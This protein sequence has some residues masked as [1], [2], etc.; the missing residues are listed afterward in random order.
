MVYR[1]YTESEGRQFQSAAKHAA[2]KALV[3]MPMDA[4][5]GSLLIGV[6][7][8]SVMAIGGFSQHG[9]GHGAHGGHG[10]GGGAHGHGGA[11]HGSGGHGHV[12]VGNG[13]PS[14]FMMVLMSPR[15]F[16]AWLIGVGLSGM[17]L[18]S[19]LG[20]ALLAV[21]AI[22]GGVLFERLLVAPLWKLA[23]RF[24]SD[25][26]LTLESALDSEATAVSAFDQEGHGLIALEID[27]QV[28]QL[29]GTLVAKDRE[30]GIKV[31]SGERLRVEEIDTARN[32]CVVS[33]L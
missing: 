12:H 9:G 8:L 31:R 11:G 20:G 4:Y 17:I 16:F 5:L 29:L 27:G 25:P 22:A 21:L 14:P 33:R 6:L 1:R 23:F 2:R 10:H 32:R 13:V 30:L 15:F 7:G 26:A 24:A 28:V 19:W 18:R 3:Y